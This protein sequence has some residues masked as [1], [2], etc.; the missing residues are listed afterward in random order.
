MSPG[1]SSVSSVN[2]SLSP[3]LPD[4]T[5]L[6]FLKIASV[7]THTTSDTFNEDGPSSDVWD[8]LVQKEGEFFF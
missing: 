1:F 7:L 3:L 5:G 4:C 8:S 6:L 2:R